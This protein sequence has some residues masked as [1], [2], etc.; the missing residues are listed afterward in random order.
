MEKKHYIIIGVVIVLWAGFFAYRIHKNK[1]DLDK[2]HEATYTK[3]VEKAKIIPQAGMAQM[4]D[5]L[6]KYKKETGRY[7]ASLEQLYPAF[8]P[9][10]AFI[11]EIEWSYEQKG[12][13][14]LLTKTIVRNN[15]RLEASIN[16]M[17]KLTTGA[18][19]T[20]MVAATKPLPK[21]IAKPIPPVVVQAPV[22][23]SGVNITLDVGE[24][25][26][27]SLTPFDLMKDQGE[28]VLQETPKEETSPGVEEAGVFQDP[29]EVVKAPEESM[30]TRASRS[31]LVWKDE[32]TGALGFG[33]VQFPDTGKLTLCHGGE[34]FNRKEVD[35][36]AKSLSLPDSDVSAPAPEQDQIASRLSNRYLVWKDEKGILGFGNVTFPDRKVYQFEADSKNWKQ[37]SN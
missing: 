18:S 15:R 19:S 25:S 8:M 2:H 13:D 29:Y 27:A 14:F 6:N 10:Q 12:A 20:T 16:S 32:K 7:P 31:Y 5:A 30:V 11:R 26:S 34:C 35:F 36:Q 9:S 17:K 3:L 33:N 37:I 1:K 23:D 28:P 21:Q 22:Q 24:D 4:V